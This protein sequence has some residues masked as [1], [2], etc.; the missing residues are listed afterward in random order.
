MDTFF[1]LN[2]SSSVAMATVE[3][4]SEDLE[5]ASDARHSGPI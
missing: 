2:E 5:T 4:L 3:Y 1:P